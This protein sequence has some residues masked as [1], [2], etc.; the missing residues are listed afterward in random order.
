MGVKANRTLF[1]RVNS[2]EYH[3]HRTTNLKKCN[4]KTNNTNPSK[5]IPQWT[6][7]LLKGKQFCF[8]SVT[9]HV[10]LVKIQVISHERGN[11]DRIVTETYGLDKWSSVTQIFHNG[12]SSEDDDC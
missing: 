7:E 1:L 9:C 4:Y 5:F 3:K 8:T 10:T 12:K 11:E 6:R 2:S